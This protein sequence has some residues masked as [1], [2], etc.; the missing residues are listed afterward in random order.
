MRNPERRG[1]ISARPDLRLSGSIDRVNLQRAVEQLPPGYKAVFV[2]HDVQGYEHNEIAEMHGL[3]D[4]EF[5]VATAQ[6]AHAPSRFAARGGAREGPRGSPG[7]GNAPERGL[8][9]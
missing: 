4:R 6:S 8:N 7:R 9:Q 3:F 5:E 2:L 1:G